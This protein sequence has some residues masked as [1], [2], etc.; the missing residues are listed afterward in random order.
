VR[1]MGAVVLVALLFSFVVARARCTDTLVYTFV[2][3]N[4]KLNDTSGLSFENGLFSFSS[5]RIDCGQYF[6]DSRVYCVFSEASCSVRFRIEKGDWYLWSNKAW[7][8]F[9]SASKKCLLPVELSKKTRI[10]VHAR[11]DLALDR[12]LYPF[13]IKSEDVVTSF[14]GTMWF[15]PSHGVVLYAIKGGDYLIRIDFYEYLNQ[16]R[17]N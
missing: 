9:F 11:S 6:I 2:A 12:G 17:S 16:S 15:H 1:N 14:A 8:K 3:V 7:R 5:Q 13:Q 10:V 4:D